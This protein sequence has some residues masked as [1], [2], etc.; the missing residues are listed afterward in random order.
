MV[1][2]GD[3]FFG[4]HVNLAARVAAAALGG[5]VVVSYLVRGV[6]QGQEFAF[7]DLGER[8]MKGFEQPLRI[9]QLR[10]DGDGGGRHLT[11]IEVEID[12]ERQAREVAGIIETPLFQDLRSQA[13]QLRETPKDS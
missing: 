10:W 2:E 8:P 11:A 4:R 6:V 5:E 13:K 12:K 1:K 9:W 7:D 3:D